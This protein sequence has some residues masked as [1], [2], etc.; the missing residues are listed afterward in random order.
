MTAGGKQV[1]AAGITEPDPGTAVISGGA[2]S[3]APDRR[4]VWVW[5]V[6]FAL[7]FAQ[8]FICTPAQTASGQAY[9]FYT[10]HGLP[11]HTPVI[12]RFSGIAV[13]P[14]SP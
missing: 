4:P 11:P 10:P 14:A 8:Q 7:L 5:A 12:L 2:A 13:A 1:K 6:P 9:W 3:A